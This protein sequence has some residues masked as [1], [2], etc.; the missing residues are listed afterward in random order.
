MTL[1]DHYSTH[2]SSIK[3]NAPFLS[4]GVVVRSLH[5]AESACAAGF[6]AEATTYTQRQVYSKLGIQLGIQSGKSKNGKFK[7]TELL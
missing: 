2:M 6:R 3:T 4:I 7:M 1:F 5:D